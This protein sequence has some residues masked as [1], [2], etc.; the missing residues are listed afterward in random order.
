MAQEKGQSVDQFTNQNF[1]NLETTRRNGEA[2]QTPVWFVELGGMLYVRTGADSGKVK[3]IR[4]NG[5]V[6]VAPCD[7]RGEL[8]GDWVDAQARLVDSSTAEQVNQ[9]FNRKYGLQKRGFELLGRFSSSKMVTIA[10]KIKEEVFSP[11]KE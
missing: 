10:I 9:L 4:N 3:R 11:A 5:L 1:I 8:Q 2:V 7:Y 6:R